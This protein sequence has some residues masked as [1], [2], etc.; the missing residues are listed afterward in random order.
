MFFISTKLAYSRVKGGPMGVLT[1]G[2]AWSAT[3]SK[4]PFIHL[5]NLCTVM[6]SNR[7]KIGL[8]I[9]RTQMWTMNFKV[10]GPLQHAIYWHCYSFDLKKQHY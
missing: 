3:F 5:H 6:L 2:S 1:Y 7:Q 4:D 10:I 8:M 9:W